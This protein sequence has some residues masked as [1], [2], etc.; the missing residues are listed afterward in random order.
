MRQ[1][2]RSMLALK[3][4]GENAESAEQRQARRL[5]LR[6]AI[7]RAYVA[8]AVARGGGKRE[9]DKWSFSLTTMLHEL[10]AETPQAQQ[11]RRLMAEHGLGGASAKPG[12]EP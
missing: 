2:R 11:I 9:F 4:S 6:V 8:Q 3:G 10:P 7:A 12:D 1:L 5:D